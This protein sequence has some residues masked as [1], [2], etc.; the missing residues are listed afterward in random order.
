MT[1]PTN[2]IH[3]ERAR[4]RAN[5]TIDIEF[6]YRRAVALRA[7]AIKGVLGATWHT[8]RRWTAASL[9]AP[10]RMRRPRAAHAW[11]TETSLPKNADLGG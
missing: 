9:R 8:M 7:E 3:W 6:Y 11:V 2:D 5:G 4:R 10:R 1:K